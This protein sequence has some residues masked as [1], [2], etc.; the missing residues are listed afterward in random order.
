MAP[1]DQGHMAAVTLRQQALQPMVDRARL[2]EAGWPEDR[3]SVDLIVQPGADA[4]DHVM[5]GDR[6]QRIVARDN[7]MVPRHMSGH[8]RLCGCGN[9]YHCWARRIGGSV[10]PVSRS[11]FLGVAGRR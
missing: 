8:Q 3:R 10:V 11:C 7:R 5:D 4:L 2:A 9:Q 1:D 6:K